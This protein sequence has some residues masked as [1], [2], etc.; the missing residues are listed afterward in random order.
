MAKWLSF[1]LVGVLSAQCLW[2]EESDPRIERQHKNALTKSTPNIY[3]LTTKKAVA[4]QLQTA[5]GYITT[6]DLPEE[7]RKVFVGDAEL[8]KVEVYGSQVIVKPATDSPAARSNLVIYTASQRLSFDVTVGPPE[9]ADFVLD[10]RF[11]GPEAQ[12]Q[13]E[14]KAKVEEKKQELEQEYQAKKTKQDENVS[15]LA[16]E[17]F[18]T[19]IQKGAASKV[20]KLSKKEGGIQVNL[21]SLSEM[22][23]KS[24][25]RFSILNYSDH[26]AEIERLV[27]GKE[28]M[29]RKGFNL[30][31]EGF[32]PVECIQNVESIIPKDSYRYGVLSFNKVFL[33]TNE[34]L[35]LKVFEKDAT[36]PL[37]I[38]NIPSEIKLHGK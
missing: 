7:A 37:E 15:K 32:A 20:L 23:D 25:I 4:Y 33:R 27:L 19:Q 14:F 16:Q 38:T 31:K 28:T 34:R 12:V 2:A 3:Q 21:L 5:L 29:V 9:L 24:Y 18:E 11:P 6:I 30:N 26:D 36:Q 22:G 1:I 8:F 17:K 13:N 10:F 35:T